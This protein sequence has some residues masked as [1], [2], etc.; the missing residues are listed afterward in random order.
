MLRK[1]VTSQ[2]QHRN[3]KCERT[4]K[5][6]DHFL[7]DQFA[8]NL[9]SFCLWVLSVGFC[10]FL[11]F[12]ACGSLKLVT[13]WPTIMA[14]SNVWNGLLLVLCLLALE[15]SSSSD[16]TVLR[17]APALRL[18]GGGFGVGKKSKLAEEVGPVI[19]GCSCAALL[20]TI[21]LLAGC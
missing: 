11:P 15:P 5:F 10:R 20:C 2:C 8:A 17:V 16:R 14:F 19:S 21:R 18:R 9:F 3:P 7:V 12:Y 13:L 6:V 4:G 1:T